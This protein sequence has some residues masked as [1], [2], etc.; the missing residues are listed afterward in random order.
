MK[1]LAE[2]RQERATKLDAYKALCDAAEAGERAFTDDEQTRLRALEAELD[3]KTG[4]LALAIRAA[5]K[6]EAILGQ[7]AASEMNNPPAVIPG[8][9][10]TGGEQGEQNRIKK[11]Y[12]F[13]KAVQTR[14]NGQ[15]QTGVELEMHQEAEKEARE[16]KLNLPSRA[17]HIPSVFMTPSSEQRALN[18]TTA[19]EG[20]EVVATDLSQRLVDPFLPDLV[21]SRLGARTM[22]GLQ[23]NVEIPRDKDYLTATWEGEFGGT[24]ETEPNFDKISLSPNRLSAKSFWG[25]Q[26]AIQSSISAESYMRRKIIESIQIKLDATILNGSGAGNVPTGILS[27][28]ITNVAIGVNGGAITWDK[29]VEVM[30]ALKDDNAE[31]GRLGWVT[32]PG[33]WGELMTT[34]VDAG[35]GIFLYDKFAP[36]RT[37]YTTTQMPSDGTKGTG[38]ALNSLLYGNWGDL[39]IGQWGGMSLLV[40]PYTVADDAQMKII[41][42]S[43]WDFI[44]EREKSFVSITDIDLTA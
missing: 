39:T 42:H 30:V 11:R 43:W 19:T 17:F 5:E 8:A 6:R 34:P 1:S 2:L 26:W 15:T 13:L 3:E 21:V 33:V 38:T 35:S 10:A 9:A 32:T 44:V 24:T 27:Q 29:L 31:Q 22:Y 37:F 20:P 16:L 36:G 23:G 28:G 12:S 18:V 7:R 40:D 25:M 41:A 14:Y 4:T